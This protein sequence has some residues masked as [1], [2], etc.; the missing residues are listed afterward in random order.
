MKSGKQR[1]VWRQENLSGLC[2]IV[3]LRLSSQF[4]SK[5]FEL[6]EVDLIYKSHFQVFKHPSFQFLSQP[7]STLNGNLKVK[8]CTF[9][10]SLTLFGVNH[11][12]FAFLL[13]SPCCRANPPPLPFFV[14][15]PISQA[16]S[17]ISHQHFWLH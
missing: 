17:P 6:S 11:V 4:I 10:M 15:L 1:M 16:A 5:M 14:N 8:I 3:K 13:I 12:L 2:K 7:T 9:E